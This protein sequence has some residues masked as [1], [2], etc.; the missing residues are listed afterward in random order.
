M[1]FFDRENLFFKKSKPVFDLAK[2]IL[3]LV[4]DDTCGKTQPLRACGWM[5][6]KGYYL[7]YHLFTFDISCSPKPKEIEDNGSIWK[8]GALSS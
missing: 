4:T 6:A 1:V 2:L 5:Q 3:I 8:R 7:P